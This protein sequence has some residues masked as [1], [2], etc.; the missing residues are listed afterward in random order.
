MTFLL[1]W[2]VELNNSLYELFPSWQTEPFQFNKAYSAWGLATRAVLASPGVLG[3][4]HSNRPDSRG[5]PAAPRSDELQARFTVKYLITPTQ[6]GLTHAC[7]VWR[8]SYPNYNDISTREAGGTSRQGVPCSMSST[9]V[10]RAARKYD[11][12]VVSVGSGRCDALWGVWVSLVERY[13]DKSLSAGRY[14]IRHQF[15]RPLLPYCFI[16]LQFLSFRYSIFI[17]WTTIIL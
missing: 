11:A 1:M 2:I 16:L 4:L 14:L 6:L 8:S 5:A 17:S 3:T 12:M 10:R 13:S 15:G 9:D 7:A